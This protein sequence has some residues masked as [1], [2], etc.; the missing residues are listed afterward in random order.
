MIITCK[1]Y[2]Y[3]YTVYKVICF[4]FFSSSSSSSFFLPFSSF[5][6]YDLIWFSFNTFFYLPI[7]TIQCYEHN[8]IE[9]NFFYI[10]KHWS[11]SSNRHTKHDNHTQT[12][13]R[14]DVW[15]L[16]KTLLLSL[17]L[18]WIRWIFFSLSLCYC[19]IVY[20]QCFFL[21]SFIHLQCVYYTFI[22]RL[23]VILMMI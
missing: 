14:F 1:Y 11:W 9:N 13:Q 18:A 22:F 15:E 17:L 2:Y 5:I 8:Q 10:F 16:K 20:F 21:L 23:S 19:F 3:Y 7:F 4:I 12:I 6:S